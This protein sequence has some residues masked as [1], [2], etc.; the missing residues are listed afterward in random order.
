MNNLLPVN[1][2]NIYSMLHIAQVKLQ[3]MK[4]FNFEK[5]LENFSVT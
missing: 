3:E 2:I 4:K 1:I 5:Y